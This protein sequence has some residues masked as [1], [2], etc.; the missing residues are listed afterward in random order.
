MHVLG[1][2][3]EEVMKPD[4][5]PQPIVV[6]VDGT[7][8][9]ILAAR[10]AAGLAVWLGE[11]LR[12]VHAMPGVDET[13][14]VLATA[15][16]TDAGQYPRE[17]GEDALDRAAA[18]VHADFPTLRVTRTL[19]H[20]RPESALVELS[21][22]ARLLV[23][24]AAD[25]SPTGALLL[26]STT[27]AVAS[28]AACPVIAWRGPDVAPNDRPIVVGIDESSPCPAALATAF[29]LAN[30]VGVGLTAVYA[31]SPQRTAVEM[32][33]PIT[34]WE[35]LQSRSRQRLSRIT[36]PY[37]DLWPK[38]RVSHVVEFGKASRIILSHASGAQMV[39]V[40][41]RRRGRLASVLLGSTGLNLLHHAP[42]PVVICPS[43]VALE[44]DVQRRASNAATQSGVGG[45]QSY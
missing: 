44:P 7:S 15:R 12:L 38:V 30:C 37:V 25:V 21:H 32:N 28:R 2:G 16:Q 31:I 29:E 27:L 43:S 11:P 22:H 20:R 10:F 13:L 33:V 35:T 3:E 42:V 1:I 26:G 9:A 19:S 14:L 8:E 6:G 36:K 45:A 39:V 5:E 4:R 24:A 41:S 40:G 17:L 34:D 18:A 23:L